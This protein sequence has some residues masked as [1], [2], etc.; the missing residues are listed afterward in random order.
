[1]TKKAI[2]HEFFI[3]KGFGVDVHLEPDGYLVVTQ[4]DGN[5]G[6]D[7][8]WLRAREWDELREKM[9][10]VGLVDAFGRSKSV[11]R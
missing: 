7:N 6:T 3:P 11:W 10:R 4:D 5:G 2:S 9:E 1:M 8:L